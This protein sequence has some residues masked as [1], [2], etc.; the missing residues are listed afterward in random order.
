[1]VAH[2]TIKA[3]LKIIREGECKASA[4][5]A[6]ARAAGPTARNR[7]NG[8]LGWLGVEQSFPVHA[9]SR[10]YCHPSTAENRYSRFVAGM[11]T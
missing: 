9:G 3:F 7:G 1:M 8:E 4:F 2:P 5:M 6:A 10:S 11:P